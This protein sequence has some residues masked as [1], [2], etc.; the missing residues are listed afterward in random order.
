MTIKVKITKNGPYLVSGNLPLA[1]ERSIIGEEG[2][3]EF[4]K[5]GE[6]YP[7]QEDYA[8]CRCGNS[9]NKPFCD[10]SHIYCK[11]NDGDESLK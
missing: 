9:K 10:G 5:K 7:K 11:F 8:L 4:W 1:K 3:P 6:N 2:E